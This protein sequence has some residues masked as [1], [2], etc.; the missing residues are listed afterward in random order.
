MKALRVPL[1]VFALPAALVAFAAHPTDGLVLE[2]AALAHGEVWRLWNAH[3]VHFSASHLAW[4]LAALLAAG[5]WLEHRRPGWLLRQA[6]VAAPLVSLALLA[7]EP[8]MRAYGGLSALATSVVVLLALEQLQS[9]RAD[10]PLWTALLLLVAGKIVYDAG[11]A[12]ALFARFDAPGVRPSAWAHAA[13]AV[14][15]LGLWPLWRHLD[16]RRLKMTPPGPV[17][18]SRR[19]GSGVTPNVRMTHKHTNIH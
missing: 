2:R 17:T 3:W 1:L 15:A 18:G 16:A 11:H 12:S 6:V 9:H 14:A 7:V 8:G 4:N 13:G 10:R 19:Q 5:T